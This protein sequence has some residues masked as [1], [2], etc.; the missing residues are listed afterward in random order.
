MISLRC[1]R[2]GEY[3]YIYFSGEEDVPLMLLLGGRMLSL[4]WEV[5][6]RDDEAGEWIPLDEY[7]EE[8]E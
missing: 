1:R 4:E 2:H 5:D 8:E 3:T 6:R 7:E